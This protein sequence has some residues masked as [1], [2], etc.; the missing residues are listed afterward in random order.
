MTRAQSSLENARA[1]VSVL[2]SATA[3]DDEYISPPQLARLLLLV[4]A[5]LTGLADQLGALL[6]T[7]NDRLSELAAELHMLTI[8]IVNEGARPEYSFLRDRIHALATR[9]ERDAKAVTP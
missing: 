2:Y 5:E 7:P 3:A 4:D 1:L 6:A 8:A 9:A